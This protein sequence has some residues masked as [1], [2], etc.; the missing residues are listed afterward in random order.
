LEP[1]TLVWSR[2]SGAQR[3]ACR[4]T[5]EGSGG[6]AQGRQQKKAHDEGAQH[7]FLL[8]L[9][10]PLRTPRQ[11]QE[12]AT[13]GTPISPSVF[14]WG[15]CAVGYVV[16]YVFLVFYVMRTNGLTMV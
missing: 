2:A 11:A 5:D 12:A 4:G 3:N 14:Y 10:I 13:Q 7:F 16:I 9:V 15:G 6:V 8:P 1:L